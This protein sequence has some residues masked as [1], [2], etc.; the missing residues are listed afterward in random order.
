MSATTAKWTL[1]FTMG[2][3]VPVF[4][5]MFVAAGF[6]PLFAIVLMSLGA[7]MEMRVVG[8]GF[9]FF[10]GMIHSLVYGAIFYM[11]ALEISYRLRKY[12]PFQVQ[13]K[14][15]K[16][17]GCLLLLSMLPIYGGGHGSFH[18]KNV[19]LVYLSEVLHIFGFN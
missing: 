10:I 2:A 16:I 13:E 5:V 4:Y 19:F 14:V 8:A 12:P 1:F 6:F 15:L 3:V 11:I 7:L 9:I 18:W 17:V